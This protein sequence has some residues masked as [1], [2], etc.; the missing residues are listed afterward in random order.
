[1]DAVPFQH[2]FKT[3]TCIIFIF[4]KFVIVQ[5]SSHGFS[6]SHRRDAKFYK[7]ADEA[8]K[9]IPDGSK[10]LVGGKETIFSAIMLAVMIMM[11]MTIDDTADCFCIDDYDNHFNFSIN[12]C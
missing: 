2:V 11:T 8:V 3:I 9:D 12:L 6:T 7:S 5:V 10:L 1:M 4:K